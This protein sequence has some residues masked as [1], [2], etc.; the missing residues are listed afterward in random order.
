VWLS[1]AMALSGGMLQAVL[2]VG[3]QLADA[4]VICFSRPYGDRQQTGVEMLTGVTNL[5]SF[6]AIGLTVMVPSGA[7][8][9]LGDVPM[10]ILSSFGTVFAAFVCGIQSFFALAMLISAVICQSKDELAAANKQH[11]GGGGEQR[12][13]GDADR[14]AARSVEGEEDEDAKPTHDVACSGCGVRPIRGGRWICQDCRASG[15]SQMRAVDVCDTCRNL[16]VV[17]SRYAS[18]TREWAT[19]PTPCQH[20]EARF[21]HDLSHT[22]VLYCEA[23]TR[24]ER[25]IDVKTARNGGTDSLEV[26]FAGVEGG[27]AGNASRTPVALAVEIEDGGGIGP[28]QGVTEHLGIALSQAT[29][30]A[31]AGTLPTR[32]SG[33]ELVG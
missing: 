1:A 16:F 24:V 4:A 19:R 8:L 29:G 28:V 21:L 20:G 14:H 12:K 5:F 31:S 7:W 15:G 30:W 18:T 32:V 25:R 13:A 9:Y 11:D 23:P 17:D 10:L 3:A 2:A 22:L 26:R 6:T 27:E 33:Q